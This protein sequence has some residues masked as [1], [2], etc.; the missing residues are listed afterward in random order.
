MRVLNGQI[1]MEKI[2]DTIFVWIILGDI[3][4][5]PIL[6]HVVPV[7]SDQ[8]ARWDEKENFQHY[9]RRRVII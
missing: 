3:R 6:S 1:W 5:Y 4:G 8:C 2:I 9:K 7:R